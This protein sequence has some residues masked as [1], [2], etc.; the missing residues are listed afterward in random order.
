MAA[1]TYNLAIEQGATF[2]L[3]ITLQAPGSGVFSLVGYTIRAQIRRSRS[4]SKATDLTVTVAAPATGVFVL[5]LSAAKTAA[6]D[7][8]TGVWDLEIT[9][10]GVVTRVLQGTVEVSPEVTR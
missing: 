10:G 9:S 7:F 2:S 1:G 8:Q 3:Q 4:H 5:G 6:L